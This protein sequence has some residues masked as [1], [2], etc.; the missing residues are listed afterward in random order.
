MGYH[1]IASVKITAWKVCWR[2]SL[3][4]PACLKQ[5]SASNGWLVARNRNTTAHAQTYWGI[6]CSGQ[7]VFPLGT[8]ALRQDPAQVACVDHSKELK[9]LKEST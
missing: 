7:C 2:S 6:L 3:M 8:G 9:E 4:L 1:V 5:L